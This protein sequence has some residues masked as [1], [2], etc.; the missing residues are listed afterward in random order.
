MTPSRIVLAF[1][2]GEVTLHAYKRAPS[3]EMVERK[4]A[5]IASS[6]FRSW[7]WGKDPECPTIEAHGANAMLLLVSGSSGPEVG[8]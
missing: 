4:A 7:E 2:G 1:P 3:I 5:E 6:V 8:V